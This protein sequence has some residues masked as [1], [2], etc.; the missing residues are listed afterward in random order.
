[1]HDECY[2]CVNML[3]VK[4]K[5]IAFMEQAL[6]RLQ[7]VGLQPTCTLS[8][9]HIAPLETQSDPCSQ[10]AL[11]LTPEDRGDPHNDCTCS[12]Y[13]PDVRADTQSVPAKFLTRSC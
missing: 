1:M 7:H 2:L 11:V 3:Y 13:A 6:Q 12:E 9:R 4:Y 10:A 8:C 5:P